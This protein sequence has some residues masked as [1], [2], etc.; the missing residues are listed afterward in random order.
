MMGLFS[1]KLVGQA[2]AMDEMFPFFGQLHYS[3]N[4][5]QVVLKRNERRIKLL[6]CPST[7]EIC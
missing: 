2:R 4:I 5:F 3:L 6:H 1:P 7:A